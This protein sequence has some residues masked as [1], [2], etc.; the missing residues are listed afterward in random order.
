MQK[1]ST[2]KATTA[3]TGPTTSTIKVAKRS[4]RV[5][6]DVSG[7]RYAI[8]KRC[9][10]SRGINKINLTTFNVVQRLRNYTIVL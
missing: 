10:K 8:I 7:C 6:V 1:R 9:L 2:K 5:V 4:R 3:K